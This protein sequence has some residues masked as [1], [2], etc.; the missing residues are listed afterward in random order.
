M[1]CP[2]ILD[3]FE[4]PNYRLCAITHQAILCPILCKLYCFLFQPS[5]STILYKQQRDIVDKAMK[6]S[7]TAA[8]KISKI[9][10]N[11]LI[12]DKYQSNAKQQC[13]NEINNKKVE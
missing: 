6:T 3:P 7:I 8:T 4:G 2:A 10:D 12:C 13:L 1:L 9:D 11:I 5:P